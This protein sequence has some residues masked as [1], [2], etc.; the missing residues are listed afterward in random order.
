MNQDS[1]SSDQPTGQDPLLLLKTLQLLWTKHELEKL[2]EEIRRGFARLEDPLAGLLAMLESSSDWKG[3]GHSLGYCITTELQLWIKEHPAVPQSGTKL[4]KL[5]ARVLGMLSQCPTNLLDPLISI[6][7]LHTADRNYLLEHVSHLYLQGNYK[8]AAILSIKLKLQP[9]QDV[10]KMCTPL[11]LQDKANLVEDYVGEY[12]ELQR[13]LLQTLDMWCD[14]SF[15]IRDITRP[16][17]GLSRYKPEKF[18]RRVLSKLVFRLL[19]RFNVDPALCPN[20]IN[21]RHLRTLNY[22]FYKRFVEKTMTEE[23]WADHIQSTVGENRWLQGHLVQSLLRH[24]GARGAARWARR[25][26]VPPEMLPRAVAEELQKLHIQDRAEEVTKA[27]NY[28]DSKKK[29]YYQLPIAREKIHFLQ[30][31]EETLQCWEKVL[32]PG[33]VVGVDMEWKPSFGMVG[34]PRVALLQLALKDEV[35]LLDLPRLLEQAEAEGEKEKLPRFIQMLYSDAA[36]TKLGYGMS[37]DLSSLAATCSALK[38]TEKQMQGVVDL[39]AVD[40]QLQWKK[41]GRKVDG[42]SPEH[43]HEERGV[44]QPEKGLSL[45]VQ[46]VLGKP[47]DKTEQLSNWEKRPLREEQI[48]YAAS[49]AYCLL[50]IYERL[51]KDPESFGLG[52]DLTESLVEKQSKKPRAK[53]QL[54]KQEA[55]SPSGQECQGP[56]MEPSCPPAPISPQ[57][58]SVVCDNMLQGL[59]RYLRCLG[60]DVRLLDNEDDHRKAA[61]IARQEGRVILTSGLPYQTLRSQVGEGR[62]FSVNCSEKA[63]EQALQVLKHFNVQVSLSDIFSRCQVCNCNKYLKVSRERMRQLVEGSRRASGEHSAGCPGSQSC[64]VTVPACDTAQPGCAPHGERA[65]GAEQS[66]AAAGLAG[67]TVLQVAAIPPGVLDRAELTDFFCCTRCGK[68]FWEGSHFGRVVSQF[69]D[70]LVASGDTQS[71]YELS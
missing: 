55:P 9:D 3:K 25:C 62:C 70:V 54:N 71:I 22:L 68:V 61:E 35:F 28:E 42:L 45:L 47:L 32:Q 30:T 13:K 44:K 36:I 19:E 20:V 26:R 49:D 65:E 37:G 53:K 17:Q 41:D 67:D 66:G 43:S 16:Y 46:H 29:D 4:K 51:C 69:Q 1:Y 38:D 8:E 57:E 15:N 64:G 31:W 27:D 23:N 48:L 40:K 50:E 63:K 33:Q 11:L 60:V 39:L 2:K 12:P 18:N 24:C 10:E 21:Q 5:Q 56:R 59:G 34:K 52:S 58:F 14:P 7:Q 6:Y